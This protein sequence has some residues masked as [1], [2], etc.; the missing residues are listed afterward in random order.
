MATK[1]N[2]PTTALIVSEDPGLQ[3]NLADWLDADGIEAIVCPG[4]RAPHFSCIGLRGAP[5]PLMA[6]ADLVLLD[7]HPEPGLL[8]DRTR[9]HD[10][11]DLYRQ[12][13]RQVVAL[14]DGATTLDL[15]DTTGVTFVE[16]LETRAAVLETVREILGGTPGG[17][18]H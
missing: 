11:L 9:R 8:V 1:R 16:R 7:L 3:E 15:A 5:C 6:A 10:L 4:P 14:V 17:A 2:R 18:S 12:N 13:G